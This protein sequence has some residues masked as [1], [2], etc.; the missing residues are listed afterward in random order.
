MRSAGC[1][2]RPVLSLALTSADGRG[3]SDSVVLLAS[4][5][6]WDAALLKRAAPWDLR[7]EVHAIDDALDEGL[8]RAIRTECDV[9]TDVSVP[10]G[11]G[12][13]SEARRRSLHGSRMSTR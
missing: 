9:H 8:I 4:L 13:P 5:A 12:Q 6:D 1:P 2:V 11:H 7:H 10:I 3:P